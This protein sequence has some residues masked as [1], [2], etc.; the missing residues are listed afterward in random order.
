MSVNFGTFTEKNELM[1][2][3]EFFS[4]VEMGQKTFLK[5]AFKLS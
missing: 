5:T 2:V 3:S 4:F 1:N